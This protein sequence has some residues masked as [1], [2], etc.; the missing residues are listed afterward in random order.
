MATNVATL[1]AVLKADSTQFDKGMKGAAGSVE[2]LEGR[3]KKSFDKFAGFAKVAAVAGAAAIVAGAAKSVAAYAEFEKGMNEVFTLLPGISEDA[4]DEMSDQVKDLS[5]DMGILPEDAIPAVYQALS[6]GVPKDNVFAFVEDATKLAVGGSIDTV[7]AVNAL[8]SVTNAYGTSVISAAEASDVMFTT[9]RLGK[10]TAGELNASLSNVI[11]IAAS[12]GV[13]FD[14]VGAALATMTAMGT[15]T[16]QATT[17]IR[18]ALVEMGTQGTIAAGHFEDAAGETFPKFIEAGGTVE[19]ALQLMKGEADKLGVG[20]G[21]LAGSVEAKMALISLTSDTGAES[22]NS[23]LQEM[24]DKAGATDLA[25][26]QMDQG[27]ARTWDKIKANVAVALVD[28]GERLAPLVQKFSDA[29]AEHLPAFIDTFVGAVETAVGFV[30]DFIGGI[31]DIIAWFGRMPRPI[32]D[33]V[34]KIGAVGAALMLL[35]ANPVI[36]GL[37]VV[38]GAVALIGAKGRESEEHLAGLHDELVT[39]GGF[40]FDT[41]ADQLGGPD[42][43][44]ALLNLG[45]SLDD[46]NTALQGTDE[47][48]VAFKQT[49]MRE[50]KEAGGYV[51]DVNG[52]IIGSLTELRDEMGDT[53]KRIGEANDGIIASQR[54]VADQNKH[55]RLDW[56]HVIDKHDEVVESLEDGLVP[57]VEEAT[58]S[59]NFGMDEMG[60]GAEMWTEAILTE[61]GQVVSGWNGLPDAMSLGTQEFIDNL[62]VTEA[63]TDEWQ[64]N[65]NTIAAAGLTEL[66]ARLVGAGIEG[67]DTVAAFTQDWNGALEAELR[68]QHVL[69]FE[70]DGVQEILNSLDISDMQGTMR[71]LQDALGLSATDAQIVADKLRQLNGLNPQFTITGT[72]NIPPPPQGFLPPNFRVNPTGQWFGHEGGTVPGPRGQ[73]VATMLLGGEKVTPLHDSANSSGGMT[74]VVQGNLFGASSVDE[75]VEL[76]EDQRRQ[77]RMRG[78]TAA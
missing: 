53:A 34:V 27:L 41:L 20:V 15:P 54:E 33:V 58:V 47:E 64:R 42:V 70:I 44:A 51:E 17:Q 57:A 39:L 11:P 29:F 65:L 13:T 67:R 24:A 66:H 3:S 46:V 59:F 35:Y 19:E 68:L 77:Y 2:E 50:S 78:G 62:I 36:A 55:S 63:A 28:I 74:V 23:N 16:A 5:K 56:D 76:L 71:V 18:Q 45:F 6:A 7:E 69:G 37:A 32:Q 1:V 14:E 8:T 21:D 72:W 9:I 25:F 4:M 75:L 40:S 43:I 31:Q 61:V 38:A 10:T 52:V 12:M 48:F 49:V 26:D 22:F 60:A 30:T 73:E